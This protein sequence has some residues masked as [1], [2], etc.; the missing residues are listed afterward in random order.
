MATYRRVFLVDARQPIGARVV[1]RHKVEG[2]RNDH[3]P[4]GSVGVRCHTAVCASRDASVS[5]HQVHQ[6]IGLGG[7][8]IR[9]GSCVAGA[10]I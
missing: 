5:L 3:V 6:A 1:A 9:S 2:R 7:D 8:Q 4:R 10:R